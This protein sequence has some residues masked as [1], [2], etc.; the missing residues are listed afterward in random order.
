M[1]FFSRTLSRLE[2]KEN[3][4]PGSGI[5]GIFTYIYHKD[6]PNV[7]KYTIHGWYGIYVSGIQNMTG[8][9]PLGYRFDA[10][11]IQGVPYRPGKTIWWVS[12]NSTF[13]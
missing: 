4:G 6:Q 7:G 8:R 12:G 5:S 3:R 10:Y 2:R 11:G 13:S 1:S 9:T